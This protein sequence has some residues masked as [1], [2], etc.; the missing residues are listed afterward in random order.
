M[1]K[2]FAIILFVLS[3]LVQAQNNVSH[4]CTDNAN[5]SLFNYN[6]LET[7]FIKQLDIT[8]L[9][10]KLFF[11]YAAKYEYLGMKE[12][13]AQIKEG[14]ITKEN[15]QQYWT[16]KLSYLKDLYTYKYL[17]F[18]EQEKQAEAERLSKSASAQ[19]TNNSCN[20][21][22]F[23]AG[24]TSNWVGQ[25]NNQGTSG[26]LVNGGGQPNQGY[27]ALTVNG[28]NSS[29][30]NTAGYVHELCNGGTDPHVPINRV[31]PGHSY[32]LR[33]G[34][35]ASYAPSNSNG[36]AV[37]PFNH[38]VIS[39]T[40]QV[41]A[42]NKT[43][44]YWYA[45][46]LDQGAG[47]GNV[48]PAS[49][50]PYFNIRMYDANNVEIACPQYDVNVTD[51]QNVGGFQSLIDPTGNHQFFYK[52][53]TPIFIPLL[54]YVGQT[55]TIKFETSDCSRGGHF[56]YAYLAVDCAPLTLIAS[57]PQPCINGN[58]TL[59]APPGL[60][61]YNWTGPGFVGSNAVQTATVNIAGIYSVSMTTYANAGQTGCTLV[62]SDTVVASTA[63]PVASFSA[64]TTCLNVSN[65]FTDLSTL[66]PNQGTLTSWNW[67]FGDGT[68]LNANN[69]THLYAAPG[70]Y[71]VSYTITSSVNCTDTYS[72]SVTVNPLPTSAFTTNTVCVGNPTSFTNTST[73]ANALFHWNFGD[74]NG[75]ST[76][77]NPNY[78]YA[79][80]GAYAVT[81]SV[82]NTYSC[83]A[84]STNTAVVNAYPIVN[85]TAPTVCYGATTIFNNTTT[86][87]TG[88]TY[89]WNFGDL[90]AI[91][92]TSTTK[93][94]SYQYTDPNSLSYNAT[95]VVTSSTGCVSS[96]TNTV[97]VNPIPAITV[98]SPSLFCW[99]DII[100]S[101]S[102]T[103]SPANTN[104]T[105]VWTNNNT[106]IGLN[107][108]G[109]GI[110]PIFTA[111]L[112]TT[113]ANITGVISITPHL[114]GCIGLPQSYSIT[115][116]PTPIVTQPSLNY[117]PGDTVPV[118]TFTASPAAAT[119][120]ITWSTVNSPFIGLNTTSGTTSIPMFYAISNLASAESNVITV[121]D[122]LNG[123]AGPTATFSITINSN[124]TAKFT[125]INACDGNPTNFIDQ[126]IPNSGVIA[127][128]NWNF[129]TGT[130]SGHS[131]SFLL[132]PAGTYTVNLQVTSNKGC[133]HDTTESV[134]VNPSAV[135]SFGAVAV[136]GCPPFTA[137]FRDTVSATPAI[138]SWNWNFGNTATVTYTNNTFTSLDY[139][140]TSHTQSSYY[141]VSLSVNAVNGCITTVT[142]NSYIQVYPRPLAG[143]TYNPKYADIIEPK[144]DFSDQSLGANGTNAYNW[145]FG[146]IYETTD[147]LAISNIANPTHL[148][149]N[150]I[151]SNYTV[152]QVV[153]NAFGCK[154]SVT[155]ILIIHEAVT[156]Y[157]PNAFSPNSDEKNPVFKGTGIG[158]NNS[159]FNLWIFD[160]WG[161]E[162]F[163]STDLEVGWDGN[164]HGNQAKEDVYVY[165]VNFTDNLVRFH[166]YHGTVT[167]IR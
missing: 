23:S 98:T 51:A 93:N 36:Q 13:F 24:N 67:N 102:I 79:N 76:L 117:C 129:G 124:P 45:V 167:L 136:A 91:N 26:T 38:Q 78:T 147:S 165:K 16:N 97:T 58:T 44:T 104:P 122:N 66:L 143:F 137:T 33:L 80:S 85:F 107:G 14:S 126:S 108:S 159:T 146:D 17:P 144:I 148:Y 119:P 54:N 149:S 131:P 153:S 70:T 2:I 118:L 8:R 113:G 105:Y 115:V 77:Q 73:P 84:L 155:E 50:Q 22:D 110:P 109:A 95:L 4:T 31:A 74:G 5:P 43:I 72:A 120:N 41:T 158:I 133:K 114:N 123:C 47:N 121:H 83:S 139:A 152:T 48:H 10:G 34:D 35:D 100:S 75:T 56:G 145:N 128:W 57:L 29:G 89:N 39:N 37:F 101:P 88:V 160:R 161:A 134:T 71:P 52:N 11:N 6:I 156:F 12:Y 112:N 82:T 20:N 163:H 18:V 9:E 154:D 46:V 142:K 30:F 132:T 92:D 164:Y 32:S 64:T 111:G 63:A 157:I 130:A 106:L 166:E 86:P 90:A 116:K 140:N 138:Q 135:V 68:T 15:A 19:R 25:W 127:Q 61:T 94:P 60:A 69:P 21:L 125:Y 81:L 49:E 3:A 141:S 65:S 103:I 96:K 7:A 99:N 40:F 1:K 59:Q 150:Q 42:A 162:I 62:L 28:L 27:G 87:A 151:P 53:W 55:V